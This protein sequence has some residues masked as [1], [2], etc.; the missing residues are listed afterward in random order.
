MV[1]LQ[2]RNFFYQIE[3]IFQY[4]QICLSFNFSVSFIVCGRFKYFVSGK[5]YAR[6][7]IQMDGIPNTSI[8]KGF[9][10]QANFEIKGAEIP[11]TLDIVEH[12][13]IA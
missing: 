5:K 12:D 6:K 7:E 8:G 13:P 9:Q 4:L 10:I 2:G 3:I 11:K 1:S